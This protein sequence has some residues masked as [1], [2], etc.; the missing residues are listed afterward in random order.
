MP[1]PLT[2]NEALSQAKKAMKLRRYEVAGRLYSQVLAQHPGHPVARKG[3]R[4]LQKTAP[5]AVSLN[6][7]QEQVDA[8][9]QLYHSGHMDEVERS[10]RQLL[11]LHPDSLTVIN[12]LGAAL[13]VLGQFE[14][15]VE[16]FDRALTLKPDFAEA[17][18][19]R[20]NALKE[21]GRLDDAVASYDK[22]I[23]LKPDFAAA[24]YNRGN[25]LRDSGYAAEAIAAFEK[26]IEI[27][28][29]FATAHR[30][31]SALK[32]YTIDDPQIEVMQD[33]WDRSGGGD[34]DRMEIGY[35]LAKACEDLGDFDQSFAFLSEANGLCKKVLPYEIDTDRKLFAD[36]KAAF[37]EIKSSKSTAVDNHPTLRPIFIVGMMRSGTSLVE[38]ILASHS[39]VHGGGELELLNRI[40]VPGFPG[41]D[42]NELRETYISEIA[43]LA[44]TAQMITDKMPLN[45]RWIG[46]IREAFPGAKIV[47]LRR[48]PMA[49]CW[50]IYKHYFPAEGNAYAN[51]LIDLAAY[52]ELYAD[53]MSFWE[54][55]YT[56]YIYD[57]CYEDLTENREE[58]IRKL[59]A[60]CELEWEDQC[61]EFEKTERAVKTSSA[62]QVRKKMYTGSSDA[63][64]RFASHLQPLADKLAS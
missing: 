2:V 24:S 60:F 13:Q 5:P 29:D 10:C 43:T 57:V 59:L 27:R 46:Y 62:M 12:L 63:W 38:Q 48:D 55:R 50:S 36:I 53:L 6:P 7:P 25:A 61:L 47:H 49:V 26:A 33:L 23:E 19:N 17:W 30:N 15:A 51:D 42:I 3:L 44:P 34:S 28:P 20:G 18:G 4:K 22:A 1:R 31:L 16:I 35:A 64:R 14:E 54:E 11:R 37:S 40:I 45:F 32:H 39:A 8:L 58:E 21:L 52:Y 56:D 41:I 9:V